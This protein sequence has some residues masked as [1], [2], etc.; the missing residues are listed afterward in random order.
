MRV[1]RTEINSGTSWNGD[2]CESRANS[3]VVSCCAIYK[4]RL[5]GNNADRMEAAPLSPHKKQSKNRGKK[6]VQVRSMLSD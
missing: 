5:G 4:L 1:L 3:K 2:F 6:N